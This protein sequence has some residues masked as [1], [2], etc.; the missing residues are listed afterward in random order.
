MD[1]DHSPAERLDAGDGSFYT[2]TGLS[3]AAS[4]L[5]P[6][7][8]LAVWSYAEATP[9]REALASVFPATRAERVR[10]RNTLTGEWE[11]DWLYLA[12]R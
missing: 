6:G 8:V 10:Y 12:R 2:S 1:V 7:G 9:F 11:T 5:A 4:H 3:A